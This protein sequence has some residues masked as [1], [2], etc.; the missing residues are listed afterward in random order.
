MEFLSQVDP[1]ALG[2]LTFAVV[3]V[4]QLVKSVMEKDYDTAVIVA[5]AGLAGAVLAPFAGNI[6]WFVGLLIGLNA[7]GL[8]TTVTR[9]GGSK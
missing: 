7:S 8:V 5:V 2:A 9:L 1:V 3:G 4:V 6:S